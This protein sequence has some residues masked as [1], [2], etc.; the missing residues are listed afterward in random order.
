MLV[1]LP[2]STVAGHAGNLVVGKLQAK[3]LQC[4]VAGRTTMKA[5]I[6]DN[7]S[8]CACLGRYWHKAAFG[9]NA[10]G[11]RAPSSPG[12]FMLL[13]DHINMMGANPLR[14][15]NLDALGP[16]FPDMTKPCDG[17]I[18]DKFVQAGKSLESTSQRHTWRCLIDG[19]CQTG[20][21]ALD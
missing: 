4:W 20:V 21:Y 3:P 17:E 13:T 15:P 9:R 18:I 12:D 6:S 16:R 10:A 7:G 14:G 8:C 19:D 1:G 2:T 11:G 5:T